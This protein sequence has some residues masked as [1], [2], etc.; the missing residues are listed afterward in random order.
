[1]QLPPNTAINEALLENVLAMIVCILTK[2]PVFIIGAPGSLKSL[3]IKL[4]RQNLRGSGSND[5]YF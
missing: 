4:V 3:M 1:M 2:I 5:R